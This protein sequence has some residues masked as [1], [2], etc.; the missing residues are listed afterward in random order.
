MKR[1][2]VLLLVMVSILPSSCGI[3]GHNLGRLRNAIPNLSSLD[4]LL[5]IENQ[6]EASARL[7]I[8]DGNFKHLGI[9]E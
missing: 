4:N 5:R 8:E 9:D 1:F 3:I 7:L 6:S 2:C